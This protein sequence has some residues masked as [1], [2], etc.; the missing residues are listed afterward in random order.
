MIRIILGG[1]SLAPH[2]GNGLKEDELIRSF[3]GDHSEMSTP[4]AIEVITLREI[5]ASLEVNSPF[6]LLART[7]CLIVFFSSFS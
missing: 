2:N 6:D 3:N 4:Y 5:N 7:K 1:I